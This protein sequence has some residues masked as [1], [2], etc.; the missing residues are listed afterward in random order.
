MEFTLATQEQLFA[1]TL[2][3]YSEKGGKF[4]MD[5]V[6]ARLFISKKTLYEM[7]H[8]KEELAVQVIEYYFNEVA[9]KQKAIH[10]DGSLTTLEKLRSLLCATPDLPIRKYHLHEL[11]MSFP[12]AFKML[13]SKLRF[14]WDQTISVIE[15]AKSEGVIRQ[16]MDNQLFIK[17]YSAAIEEILQE[18][19]IRNDL[20]FRRQQEEIV[21]ILLN[22]I[23]TH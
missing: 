12:A 20:D 14:G 6:A 13:D 17:L 4:T 22:G 3:L 7:V 11:R 23:C 8:S 9:A 1:E 10:E 2:N 16:D 19:E 18:N 15:Q 21:E 5:E